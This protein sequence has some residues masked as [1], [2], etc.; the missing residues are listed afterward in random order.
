MG[1]H[2]T[3]ELAFTGHE[4]RAGTG[5][6]SCHES[7]FLV[8]IQHLPYRF[9]S[10]LA[11]LAMTASQRRRLRREEE[12]LKTTRVAYILPRPGSARR[13]SQPWLYARARRGGYYRVNDQGMIERYG[14]RT[15]RLGAGS[16]TE[17][18]WYPCSLRGVR[19]LQVLA[20]GLMVRKAR[21]ELGNPALIAT[22]LHVKREQQAPQGHHSWPVQL[23][24]FSDEDG[25]SGTAPMTSRLALGAPTSPEP[26]PRENGGDPRSPATRR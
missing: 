8:D 17:H 3:T 19:W 12:L 22:D 11:D 5:S 6:F 4:G 25:E 15:Q 9:A 24:L 1:G 13:P 2:T 14:K 26:S 21:D 23:A 16:V 10:P 20:E 18:R 7:V